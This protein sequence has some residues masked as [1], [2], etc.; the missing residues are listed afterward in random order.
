MMFRPRRRDR[1]GDDSVLD[2]AI[3]E[4]RGESGAGS[5]LGDSAR[6][7][8][9]DE[10]LDPTHDPAAPASLFLP[11]R[12]LALAGVLPAMLGVALMLLLGHAGTYTPPSDSV[13][14]HVEKSAGQLVFRIEDGIG[15]HLVCK[16][17]VPSRFD[18]GRGV[19]VENG[20]YADSVH[21]GSDIAFYRID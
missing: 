16:S 4:W 15:S 8:I 12:R 2:R 18:C 19:V 3:A 10:S 17:N 1:H 20:R 13:R 11:A 21:D 5:V 6:G 7:R 14:L 9:I